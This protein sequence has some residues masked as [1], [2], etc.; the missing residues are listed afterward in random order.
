MNIQT[1]EIEY[2]DGD[3][4]LAGYL[5]V[6]VSMPKPR[7]AV[8]IAHAFAGRDAHACE[9]ARQLASM[10]YVGFALDVYGNGVLGRDV[11]ESMAL[12]TPLLNDRAL[13]LRR[14]LAGLEALR[15]Q[16]EVDEAQIAAIGYC[17]GGLCVLD[18]ARSGADMRGVASFHGMFDP[19]PSASAARITAKILLLHGWSDPMVLPQDVIDLG[20]ELTNAK[21]DWQLHAYG[22]AMHGFTQPTANDPA[23]GVVYDPRADQRSWQ[24]LGNFLEEVFG[25]AD[26]SSRVGAG[27]RS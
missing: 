11:T 23:R 25:G 20:V 9:R 12:M 14:M 17:F 8:V 19:P 6:D 4:T 24:A 2:R 5:A 16:S 26:R 21:A 18:L 27:D 7:P 10:G 15:A 3:A 22:G 13:L 1:R